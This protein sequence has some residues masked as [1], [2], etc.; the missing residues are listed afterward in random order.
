MGLQRDGR[1]LIRV[2]GKIPIDV[3]KYVL[4]ET[5]NAGEVFS[6]IERKLK[7]QTLITGFYPTF[8][9]L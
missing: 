2:V 5:K 1:P 9:T 6:V 8:T 7:Q 3:F 4:I